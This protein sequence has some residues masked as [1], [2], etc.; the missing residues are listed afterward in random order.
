MRLKQEGPGGWRQDFPTYRS[1]SASRA[2]SPIELKML[3]ALAAAEW[4]KSSEALTDSTDSDFVRVG[5]IAL[6]F[7]TDRVISLDAQIEAL[8]PSIIISTQ[9]PIL[10]YRADILVEASHDKNPESVARL[11]V[12]CDGHAYHSSPAAKNADAVRD[13]LMWRAGYPVIRF[14]GH[15]INNNPGRCAN[16]VVNVIS[17]FLSRNG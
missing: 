13:A 14:A 12:E 3:R 7:L 10:K 1:D 9:A 15:E 4:P 2:E 11:V 17:V 5:R 6:S 8:K 16:A